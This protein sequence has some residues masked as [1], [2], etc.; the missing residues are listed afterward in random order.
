MGIEDL[1][2]LRYIQDKLGGS[3][4]LRSGAKAYR[5]RLHNKPGMIN[6]INLINGHIYNSARLAQLHKICQ[7]L[8]LPVISSV[9]LDLNSN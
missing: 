5:Y 8:N 4:R 9:P 3:I 1:A 6:L 7:I 2:L